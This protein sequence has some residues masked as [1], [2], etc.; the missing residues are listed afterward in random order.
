M[1]RG[2]DFLRGKEAEKNLDYD[3]VERSWTK[4]AEAGNVEA[5]KAIV[6]FYH[7]GVFWAFKDKKEKE[8]YC[9]SDKVIY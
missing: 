5:L 2:D 1:P 7:K 4:A 8:K 6:S 3:E 9:N